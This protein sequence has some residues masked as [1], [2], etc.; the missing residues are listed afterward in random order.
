MRRWPEIGGLGLPRAA[1]IFGLFFLYVWLRIDPRLI[2]HVQEPVFF[3]GGLFFAFFLGHPGGVTEYLSA[4]FGQSYVVPW[5]GA[6][7]ITAVAVMICASTYVFLKAVEVSHAGF[8]SVIPATLLLILHNRYRYDLGYDLGLL[9]SLAGAALYA[10]LPWRQPFARGL[11]F[12]ALT[13]PIYWVAAGPYLLFCLAAATSEHLARRRVAAMGCVLAGAAVPWVATFSVFPG[14]VRDAY[15]HLLPVSGNHL[16][17]EYAV[18]VAAVALCVYA[19]AA[20]L[21]G[22]WRQARSEPTAVT[23]S[24]GT[25][26]IRI[27]RDLTFLMVMAAPVYATFSGNYKTMM[28]VDYHA[29]HKRWPQVLNEARQLTAY[30]VLTVYN[31]QRALSHLGRLSDEMFSYPH[32]AN[33]PIFVPSPETPSSLLVLCDNLMELGHVNKAEHMAQEALEIYG[34]RPSILK[35]LVAINVLKGRPAAARVYLG[36]L[37]KTL[38]HRE[39]AQRRLEELAVDPHLS[40]NAELAKVRAHM[41]EA[42]YPGFFTAEELLMQLLDRNPRNMM[43]FDFLMG[44]YLQTMQL[45][46]IA[47]SIGR[48]NAF[49]DGLPPTPLPR[50]YEEAV[51]LYMTQGRVQLGVV[52]KV[53]LYGRQLSGNTL[54]R[55]SRFSEVLAANDGDAEGARHKLEASYRDTYWYYYFFGGT[56]SGA[57]LISRATRPV[58]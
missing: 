19:P 13:V 28:E 39:W 47:G 33:A 20:A 11:A 14:M 50:L 9:L 26:L 27:S 52:P 6:F 57:P 54:R 34:D 29:R 16:V 51:M 43:A 55:Y 31:V 22:A 32:L 15:L 1:A 2:Y 38:L 35:R 12:I 21:A 41:V 4:L 30:N 8:V 49:S 10:S 53:P 58:K 36:L 5:L 42:N 3:R 45:D 24:Q 37:E 18:I 25:I 40:E 56:E 17:G 23:K 48:L 7:V 44:H 46:K